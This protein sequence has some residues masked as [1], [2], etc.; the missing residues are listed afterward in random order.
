MLEQL[1]IS[2]HSEFRIEGSGALK[3]PPEPFLIEPLKVD[4]RV[5]GQIVQPIRERSGKLD[6]PG[7]SPPVQRIPCAPRPPAE[8]LYRPD[9]EHRPIKQVAVRVLPLLV[10][11]RSASLAEHPSSAAAAT[12][13]TQR[14]GKPIPL[15]RSA[16][17]SGSA[18]APARLRTATASVASANSASAKTELPKS[19]VTSKLAPKSIRSCTASA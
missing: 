4:R 9:I 19:L 18:R 5:Q 3:L 12:A 7:L 1:A 13:E 17:A 6:S 2:P 16:A 8:P 11:L 10:H 14:P 15:P